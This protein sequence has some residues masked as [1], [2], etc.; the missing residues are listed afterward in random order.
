MRMHSQATCTHARRHRH[1]GHA[2]G[3]AREA[4]YMR[5]GAAL[6]G[7]VL[8]V[9]VWEQAALEGAYEDAME[10]ELPTT[11]PKVCA[12]W[13]WSHCTEDSVLRIT[14]SGIQ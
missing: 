11:G 12:V 6:P 4:Y 9:A 2:R 14:L 3:Y 1:A 7:P 13:W 8:T 5:L 10:K